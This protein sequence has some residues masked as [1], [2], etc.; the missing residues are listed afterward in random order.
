[1]S[2]VFLT[3]KGAKTANKKAKAYIAKGYTDKG[4][5]KEPAIDGSPAWQEVASKDIDGEFKDE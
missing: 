4:T 5:A 3:A 1:V 2:A